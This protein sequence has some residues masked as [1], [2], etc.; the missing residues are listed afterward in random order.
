MSASTKPHSWP[1]NEKLTLCLA[2]GFLAPD[3]NRCMTSG[4]ATQAATEK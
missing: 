1:E 4:T 2:M 3:L